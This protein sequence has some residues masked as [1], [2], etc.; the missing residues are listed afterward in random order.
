MAIFIAATVLECAVV[1]FWEAK[2][3]RLEQ[4]NREEKETLYRLTRKM[5]GQLEKT[6]HL[7]KLLKVIIPEFVSC[8]LLESRS[9]GQCLEAWNIRNTRIAH[10]P[11]AIGADWSW[12]VTATEAWSAVAGI[13]A[14]LK[15]LE[16]LC[17]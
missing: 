3:K 7:E 6:T 12:R 2:Q 14:L 16:D 10:F 5:K 9:L 1:K 15:E 8:A 17:H 4:G 13:F 11:E